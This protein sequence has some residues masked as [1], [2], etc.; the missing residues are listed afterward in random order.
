MAVEGA[1]AAGD[2]LRA[3]ASKEVKR[4]LKQEYI[5]AIVSGRWWAMVVKVPKTIIAR[6]EMLLGPLP[7]LQG[8]TTERTG[9]LWNDKDT[10]R[11]KEKIKKKILWYGVSP[12][13]TLAPLVQGMS[14]HP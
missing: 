8:A 7:A 11:S 12:R 1:S 9:L 13:R 3:K 14:P 5:V 6:F 2:V 4:F 10:E